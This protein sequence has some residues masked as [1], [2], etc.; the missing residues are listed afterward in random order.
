[1]RLT[2]TAPGAILIAP[3]VVLELSLPRAC[4]R[5]EG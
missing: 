2:Q 5:V 1:M 4:R 3:N